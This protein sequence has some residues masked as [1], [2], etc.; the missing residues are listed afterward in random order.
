[1]YIVR[2]QSKALQDLKKLPQETQRW[3]LRKLEYF[4]AS[5][6]PLIFAHP[7]KNTKLGAYRFRVGDYRIIFDLIEG[8][9]MIAA[10]GHR[11][12]IYR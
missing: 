12:E 9:I 7:L 4:A 1:M 10:V 8:T 6:S 11:R 5:G 3:I 2:F